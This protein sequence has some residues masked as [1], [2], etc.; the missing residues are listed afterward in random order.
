MDPLV[1]RDYSSTM[2]ER[3]GNKVHSFSVYQRECIKGSF[4]FLGVNCY[5][6]LWV[7]DFSSGNSSTNERDFMHDLSIEYKG[8]PNNYTFHLFISS[9]SISPMFYSFLLKFSKHFSEGK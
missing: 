7:S 9:H 4:D 8:N 2:K 6:T 3:T 1:N 5:E